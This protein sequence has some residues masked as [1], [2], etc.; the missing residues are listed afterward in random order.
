MLKPWDE[1]T[2]PHTKIRGL[3]EVI[4]KRMTNAYGEIS[5]WE[6]FDYV[7]V[8]EDLEQSFARLKTILEAERMRRARQP[9]MGGFVQGLLREDT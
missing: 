2:K 3:I 1:R 5:R 8:N 7:L 6:N 4:K 9:W